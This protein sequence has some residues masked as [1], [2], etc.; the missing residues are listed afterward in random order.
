MADRPIIIWLRRDLRLE[1][2]PALAA[3][4]GSGAPP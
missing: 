4:T 3:A 1:D 2:N